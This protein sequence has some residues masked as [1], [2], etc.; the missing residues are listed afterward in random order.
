MLEL[1]PTFK[2]SAN[3]SKNL[4][5]TIFLYINFIIHKFTYDKYQYHSRQTCQHC[6]PRTRSRSG[7][8]SLASAHYSVC[9]HNNGSKT[10]LSKLSVNVTTTGGVAAGQSS[11]TNSMHQLLESHQYSSSK[12]SEMHM[13]KSC[14]RNQFYFPKICPRHRVPSVC[15]SDAGNI[16]EF[17]YPGSRKSRRSRSHLSGS[18]VASSVDLNEFKIS[19]SYFLKKKKPSSNKSQISSSVPNK[20]FQKMPVMAAANGYKKV[21]PPKKLSSEFVKLQQQTEEA[22]KTAHF[23]TS[24]AIKINVSNNSLVS[25]SKKEGVP[26]VHFHLANTTDEDDDDE[27]GSIEKLSASNEAYSADKLFKQALGES[28]SREESVSGGMSHIN[29]YPNLIQQRSEVSNTDV[30][31]VEED[32]DQVN[33]SSANPILEI[34]PN[35]SSSNLLFKLEDDKTQVAVDEK[36]ATAAGNSSSGEQMILNCEGKKSSIEWENYWDNLEFNAL[37][38]LNI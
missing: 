1:I 11:S 8:Q 34:K 31:M 26:R 35:F 20:A 22:T 12:L 32:A 7:S 13:H 5:D 29:T 25:R 9:Y 6:L 38:K 3:Q 33:P 28:S 10:N 17:S 2:V 30:D 18:E 19:K 15:S 27:E 24:N 23:T 4:I 16:N 36:G 37:G 14:S 21:T